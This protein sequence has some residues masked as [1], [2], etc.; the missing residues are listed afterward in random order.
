MLA[1]VDQVFS[2]NKFGM[3]IKSSCVILCSGRNW[4]HE[5]KTLQFWISNILWI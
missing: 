5:C 3:K 1:A 4:P 2:V